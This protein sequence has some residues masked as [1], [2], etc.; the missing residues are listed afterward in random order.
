VQ[1]F[2]LLTTRRTVLARC[3]SRT[4]P[5]D[6]GEGPHR[7]SGRIQSSRSVGSPT[8]DPM[9]RTLQGP[10]DAVPHPGRRPS[11]PS[12]G[13]V[14]AVGKEALLPAMRFCWPMQ[15]T[16][17]GSPVERWENVL[18]PAPAGYP[19]RQGRR[20][21]PDSGRVRPDLELPGQPVA[22]V[23]TTVMVDDWFRQKLK[24]EAFLELAAE[25]L[26]PATKRTPNAV[27]MAHEVC[28][29][30]TGCP[31][32]QGVHVLLTSRPPAGERRAGHGT[33]Q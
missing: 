14:Q 21:R 5:Q 10:C 7:L 23:P 15:E 27:S 28:A 19:V 12:R 16:G 31:D 24:P 1:A 3:T 9:K 8:S 13:K 6:R 25:V 20:H 17:P 29:I 33:R 26:D 4:G 2:S 22:L 18:Y 11:L 32:Q 30:Q